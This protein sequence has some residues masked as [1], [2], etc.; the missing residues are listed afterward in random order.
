MADRTSHRTMVRAFK[1]ASDELSRFIN[2]CEV[3]SYMMIAWNEDGEQTLTRATG[4]STS[5][6]VMAFALLETLLPEMEQMAQDCPC[7]RCR[8][9][10]ANVRAALACLSIHPAVDRH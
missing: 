3:S 7:A 8:Q 4:N 2:K 1:K 10:V 9:H 5:F 6:G